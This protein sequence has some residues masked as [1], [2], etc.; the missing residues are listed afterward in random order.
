MWSRR[1]TLSLSVVFL[2]LTAAAAHCLPVGGTLG[3]NQTWSGEISLR[4]PVVIGP[5]TVLVIAPG[6]KVRPLKVGAKITIQGVM[7]AQGTAAQPIAF[8]AV[9]GWQGIEFMEAVPGSTLEHVR[10]NDAETA[11]SS[12]A[13][14]FAVRFC[15]FENCGTAV[16]LLRES[17]PQIENNQFA[18]NG[19]GIDNETKSSP[20]IRG[21]YFSE[22]KKTAILA[23]HN[24]SGL[25]ERN[26]FEKNEKGIGLIQKYPDRIIGN[27]FRENVT[28]IFCNQTQS[29]PVIRDNRFE[30]NGNALFNFSS[31]YPA[32]EHNLFF[33]NDT[34]IRNDQF[35]TPRV[36]RNH[37]RENK[38]A[39]YSYRKSDP[40]IEHNLIENNQLAIFCDYSSYPI[41]HRNNFLKNGMGVKLG[42]YQSGD[43]EKRFGSNAIRQKEAEARK[44]RNPLFAKAPTK[45]NNAVDVSENWW[46]DDTAKLKKAGAEGNL[47]MFQDGRDQPQVTYE[48]F[49]PESYA[50]DV[51]R[52]AP[53]LTAPVADC[54][55]KIKPTL[56]GVA[57][58]RPALILPT[59]SSQR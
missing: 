23:S 2:L 57:A 37:F 17:N 48:G 29:S 47:E 42:I 30:K 28:G 19:I 9:P 3:G 31:A 49:G 26:T 13:S 20:L 55:A 11:I 52:F 40:V 53:W 14:S 38:T 6:T 16:K 46:G 56:T 35:S 27:T 51:I 4:E 34:A 54:G 45:V 15:T 1:G 41:V 21:N 22:H 59:D 39:V 8:L 25:I 24:S 33:G 50:V 12:S 10:F 7:K 32:V 44:S 5:K 18:R 36:V 43:W 58:G